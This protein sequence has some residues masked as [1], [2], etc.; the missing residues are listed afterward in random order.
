MIGIIANPSSGKDIRRLVSH[1]TVIDN[2]EKVNIVERIILAA[3]ACGVQKTIIMPDTCMLGYRVIDDLTSFGELTSEIEML[4]FEIVGDFT[5]TMNSARMMEEMGCKCLIVLGGDGTSRAAAKGIR[6]IPLIGISTGTNN[7]YPQF[8]E[9]TVV[10]MAVAAIASGKYD[11]SEA[12]QRDKRIEIYDAKGDLRDIALVD[13][14]VSKNA[15]V[16][17]RAIWKVDDMLQVFVCRCHPA[18]IGFSALVGCRMIVQK[19]EDAGVMLD[20]TDHKIRT[21]V[22]IAAGVLEEVTVGDPR[23]LELNEEVDFIAPCRGVFAL[24]GERELPFK[25]GE[26]FTIKI[27]RDGPVGVDVRRVIE[28]AQLGGFF[29]R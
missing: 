18:S 1:A 12:I 3:Q 6:D 17:A 7:V 13:L 11:L 16:G 5:D 26:H 2:T 25:E 9:G 8:L 14:V 24:D 10:G 29:D 23:R 21:M 19:N 15:Y 20:L 27:T 22:P 28:I 4:D